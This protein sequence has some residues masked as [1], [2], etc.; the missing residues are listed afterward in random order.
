M[1]VRW[2]RH[3][4]AARACLIRITLAFSAYSLKQVRKHGSEVACALW[5]LRNDAWI[6]WK[7]DA[8]FITE[9]QTLHIKHAVDLNDANEAPSSVSDAADATGGKTASP[10]P[11]QRP[12]YRIAKQ[13]PDVA[14]DT[15]R[16]SKQQH[17]IAKSELILE[18]VYAEQSTLEANGFLHFRKLSTWLHRCML[19]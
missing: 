11:T 10:S 18:E 6:R 1:K 4:T 8:H 12:R 13:K 14:T 2:W 16:S 15:N 9:Q 3:Q 7:G 17:D 5:L 19:H